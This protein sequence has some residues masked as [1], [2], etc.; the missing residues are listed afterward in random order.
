MHS[1]IKY[2]GWIPLTLTHSREPPESGRRLLHQP[3]WG[4][5]AQLLRWLHVSA[6]RNHDRI[7]CYADIV[8][9]SLAGRVGAP[10]PHQKMI[11]RMSFIPLRYHPA[12]PVAI[13]VSMA[14]LAL[15]LLPA[16]GQ[17][18]FEA[19]EDS[20]VAQGDAALSY[21]RK[22]ADL[23]TGDDF[24]FLTYEPESG[25]IFQPATL[26]KIASL[27]EEILS[28]EGV[29]EVTTILDA[30]LLRN[31]PVPLA[32]ITS[33]IKTLRSES[34]DIALA[35]EELTGSPLF[36]D[37]L[38][39]EEAT[40]TALRIDPAGDQRLQQLAD[41]QRSMSR[42]EQRG[43]G[44]GKRLTELESDYRAA[45]REF[46]LKRSETLGN[47]KAIRDRIDSGAVVHLAGVPLVAE[48]MI[49]YVRQDLLIFGTVVLVVVTLV[50]AVLFRR[51]RWVISPLFSTF[52]AIYLTVGILGWIQQ[53]V[54]V[55]SSNFISLLVIINISFSI[56]LIIRYR[57]LQK[58]SQYRN[59]RHRVIDCLHDKFP[60]CLF[61]TITT[62]V[63]FGSLI[64]SDIIPVRDFGRIMCISI[65][66]SFLVT[67]SLFTGILLLLP[68][69]G[70]IPS[71]KRS[72]FIDWLSRVV[73]SKNLSVLAG[74]LILAFLSAVGVSLLSM[75]NKFLDYFR[76][77]TEIYQSLS[78]V[79]RNLGGTTPME[80]ILEF[81]PYQPQDPA[82]SDGIFAQPETDN[83]PARYWYTPDK[84]QQVGQ[85]QAFVSGM[86]GVGKTVSVA[87]FAGMARDFNKGEPLNAVQLAAVL[88]AVP[89]DLQRKLIAPYAAPEQGLI[90]LTA[91]LQE[92]SDSMT[93][94][95]L[96]EAIGEFSAHELDLA[97]SSVHVTGMA[98]LFNNMLE[99]LYSSQQSTLLFVVVTTLLLFLFLLRSFSLA[100]I[101][102]VPN[103][104]AAAIVLAAMGFLAIPLD[105]M[106]ITIA[107]IIIGIGVD[108]AIHYLHRFRQ[109]LLRDPDVGL[110]VQNSHRSVGQAILYTSITVMCGFSVLVFSNFVPTVYFGFLTALAMVL[111]L[112][113]N[114]SLLPALLIR[115]YRPVGN[116]V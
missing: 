50:L 47:L 46:R 40:L 29:S 39:N 92:T 75:D 89:D 115:F 32:E 66:V 100:L 12:Y 17:F 43:S 69:N 2:A 56:H 110:A 31:P 7:F 33:N 114:L 6:N 20:L 67:Y 101:G 54:T 96:I 48:D 90:R 45:Y 74:A 71:S 108:D 58:S 61:M 52:A 42:N 10:D 27:K 30:P 91:R 106:T 55:V 21:Y 70:R 22:I 9:R 84:I 93:Y 53:P 35:R 28:I 34:V 62:M 94:G 97:R 49:N 102:L 51:L 44:A 36:Q 109:E 99:N 98:V 8:S 3:A 105:M 11:S 73:V 113:A 4:T 83:D 64:T 15:I 79:D 95:G 26:E 23:F 13:L 16:T 86:Q 1:R 14:L 81:D 24:L 107:A 65:L 104:L 76:A 68:A 111:A 116:R 18:R 60:S 85:L 82:H 77:D 37:L 87:T 41:K 57:E 103:L 78:Y 59:D 38:L 112:L 25:D 88:G 72:K 19:S 5:V 80:V 63:A